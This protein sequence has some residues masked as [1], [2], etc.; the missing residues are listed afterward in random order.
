MPE[1]F[2]PVYPLTA[3][4]EH[5]RRALSVAEGRVL[6]VFQRSFYVQT[7]RGLACLGP[8]DMGIGPLNAL[9]ALPGGWDWQARN[10]QVGALIRCAS[11]RFDIDIDVAGLCTL[12]RAAATL[13][14]PP[15]SGSPS[16]SWSDGLTML[17]GRLPRHAPR[18]LGSAIPALLAG[19]L[20]GIDSALEALLRPA[21]EAIG[22]CCVWFQ[23]TA[24][25]DAPVPSPVAGLIGLGPGLTPAGDDFLAGALLALHHL[26]RFAIARRLADWALPL[27]R[28]RSNIISYAHLVAAADGQGARTVHEIMQALETSSRG[29][30]DHLLQSIDAIGHSSGWDALAGVVAVCASYQRD[31]PWIA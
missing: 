17:A 7:Q 16:A 11:A 29:D 9:C 25:G 15:A 4:G 1:A 10:L 30:L 19:D 3:L 24:G 12:S 31:G 13:W 22:E 23:K 18:G 28:S 6:A 21:S 26:R 20:E 14:R 2:R 8:A 27:A 5:A